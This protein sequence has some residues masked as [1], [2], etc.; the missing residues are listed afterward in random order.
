MIRN[1]AVLFISSMFVLVISSTCI[2]QESTNPAVGAGESV[3]DDSANKEEA[4]TADEKTKKEAEEKKKEE[5]DKKKAEEK[6]KEEEIKA[7]EEK[8]LQLQEENLDTWGEYAPDK[9]DSSEKESNNIWN[10]DQGFIDR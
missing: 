7:E 8:N 10:D 2:C 3:V 9:I 5:E 4:A 6:A 1:I